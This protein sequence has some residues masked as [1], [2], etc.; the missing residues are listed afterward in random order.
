M[1]RQSLL[2][3]ATYLRELALGKAPT[4]PVLGVCRN[5]NHALNGLACYA[6]EGP[7]HDG[8]AIVQSYS[9]EWP[10]YSGNPDW[11][12]RT[13]D[14]NLPRWAWANG[15]LRREFCAWLYHRI[16]KDY[17]FTMQEIDPKYPED[18]TCFA[19]TAHAALR[20]WE[21]G[22]EPISTAWGVCGNLS[23][24]ARAA[25]FLDADCHVGEYLV[26]AYC[27]YWP[28]YTGNPEY[29]ICSPSEY[30]YN[31]WV[32]NAGVMRRKFCGFLADCLEVDFPF[33]RS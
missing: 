6:Y 24:A 15:K 12:I 9:P 11:P 16:S 3:A 10:E 25:G 20:D 18:G 21:G 19:R 13:V 5:L 17:E 4:Y 22:A 27:R 7:E 32:Q 33:L 29:P 26:K 14:K 8:Y 30:G 2:R 1:S 23:R 31:M 28:D